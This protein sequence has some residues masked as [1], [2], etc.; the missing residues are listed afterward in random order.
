[1]PFSDPT[2]HPILAEALRTRHAGDGEG[3][4]VLDCGVG[5]GLTG[6]IIRTVW[7]KCDL[8]G[9]EI[10][11]PYVV[12]GATRN[13]LMRAH[14]VYFAVYDSLIIGKAADFREFLPAS[15][16]WDVIVFG[17][18]LEHVTEADAVSVVGCA[19]EKASS[20]LVTIPLVSYIEGVAY[21]VPQGTVYGNPAEAHLKH[22]HL[23]EMEDLGFR[24]VRKGKVSSCLAWDKG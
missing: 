14:G 22:W 17:A 7:P 5:V 24:L 18:S 6:K 13:K 15:T 23:D 19:Q 20:V 16:S 12:D 9:L 21:G 1:M 8:T 3:L 10:F 4:R 11:A 2:C